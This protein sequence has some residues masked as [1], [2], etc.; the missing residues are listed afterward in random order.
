MKKCLITTIL[1]F[2]FSLLFAQKYGFEDLY[3]S[4]IEKN[5]EMQSLREEYNRSLLDVKDAYAGFGPTVDLQVSGTYMLKPPVDAIYLNVDDVINSI[6]WPTGVKPSGTGQYVKIYDGMENTLYTFQLSIM[7]P[8]YTWGKLTNAVKLYNQIS[9]IKKSQIEMKQQQLETELQ[10]RLISLIYLNRINKIIED[11]KTFVNRLVKVS[12]SAEK[13]GMILHQDVVDAKIQSKE[14]EIAQQDLQEQINNQL[15][16]LVRSTGIEDLSLEKI[17]FKID[18]KAV[19]KILESNKD[20][21]LEK[22]LSGNQLSIKILTQLKEVNQIAVEIAEGFI[23]WKPDIAVQASLG[24]GGS[25]LPLLESNWLRKDDYTANF[26]IGIKTTIW[27][28]GKKLNDISRKISETK[29]ADINSLDARLTIKKT[30]NEQWNTAEVCSMKI[31]YLDLKIESCDAKIKQ[32]ETIFKTGYGSETD[33]LKAKID[34]CNQQ[35]EKEKQLLSQ[36]VACMTLNH[37]CR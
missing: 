13:S 11:E 32:Q 1:F 2:S 21:L 23:Y 15:L 19:S 12:E 29:T 17:D 33:V 14:L 18:E 26:S 16:E 27:D 25:R 20:E 36:A 24:Y 22:A 5:P 10:T 30:F 37:L 35:I 4:T 3:N 6:Q 31:E 9:E 7:Q 34:K 28:G 8:V